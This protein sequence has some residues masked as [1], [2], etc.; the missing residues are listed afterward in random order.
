MAS[1]NRVAILKPIAIPGNQRDDDVMD[2][3]R[4]GL[5][6]VACHA[7]RSGGS[8]DPRSGRSDAQVV[9]AQQGGVQ[10]ARGRDRQRR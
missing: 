8:L 3:R 5:S 10:V 9:E 1:S 2:Q 7:R 6:M 4:M